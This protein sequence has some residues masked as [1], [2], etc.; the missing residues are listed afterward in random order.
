MKRGTPRHP[1]VY[2]LIQALGLPIRSRAVVIG[3][4]ELLWH[5]TAEFAP[6]GDVGRFSDDRIESAMD[7]AGKRG[8]L[9]QALTTAKW[10]DVH[11][12]CRLVVHDW[13]E[14][15]D[16]ATRKKLLRAGL[17]FLSLTEKVTGQ[18]PQPVPT[19]ADNGGLPLP[20]P[21]PKPEPPAAPPPKPPLPPLPFPDSHSVSDLFEECYARHPKKG[22]RANAERMLSQIS[23]TANEGFR[24]KFRLVHQAWCESEDWTWKNGA[25]AP[26]F[27]EWI[28][29]RGYNYQ[30]ARAS[31]KPVQRPMKVYVEP[32][33]EEPNGDSASAQ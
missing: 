18:C 2:D 25:K 28:I 3:Y 7:W 9:V 26:Y 19:T 17:K 27:D 32:K 15:A 16:D 24:S 22:H 21:E 1:K 6:Q 13:H 30:P 33:Y 4:L 11:D 8:K 5:F 10:L 12:Q 14:H 31:P 29:D 23:E 20:E